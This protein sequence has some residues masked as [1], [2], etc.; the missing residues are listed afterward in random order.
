MYQLYKRWDTH[1]GQLPPGSLAE[2]AVDGEPPPLAGLPA[3]S[4]IVG[5]LH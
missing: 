5:A 2:L 1:L 4:A 3:F